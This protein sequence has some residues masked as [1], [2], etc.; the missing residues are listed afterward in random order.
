MQLLSRRMR[1]KRMLSLLKI[2]TATNA[3]VSRW[4]VEGYLQYPRLD[5]ANHA[6]GW[7]SLPSGRSRRFERNG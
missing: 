1:K 4:M 7:G 5:L 3:N 2:D 6:V